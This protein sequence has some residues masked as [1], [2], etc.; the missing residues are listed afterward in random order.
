MPFVMWDIGYYPTVRHVKL[1]LTAICFILEVSTTHA[2][3]IFLVV[4]SS[5]LNKSSGVPLSITVSMECRFNSSSC[6]SFK[7]SGLRLISLSTK[8]TRP[9]SKLLFTI[10]KSYLFVSLSHSVSKT[11]FLGSCCCFFLKKV[12]AFFSYSL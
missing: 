1:V 12:L 9:F 7:P 11:F 5:A 10:F 3:P 2:I 6:L 4:W 8:I